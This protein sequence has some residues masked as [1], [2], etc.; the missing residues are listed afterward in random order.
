LRATEIAVYGVLIRV[1]DDTAL[2]SKGLEQIPPY[3]SYEALP[4]PEFGYI[5][6]EF[7]IVADCRVGNLES[8]IARSESNLYLALFTVFADDFNTSHHGV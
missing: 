8:P 2:V 7:R 4:I 6:Q 1:I 5:G 3:L